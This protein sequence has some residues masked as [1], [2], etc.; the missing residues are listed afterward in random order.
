MYRSGISLVI[1]RVCIGA[2]V[3]SHSVRTDTGGR[4]RGCYNAA[5]IVWCLKEGDGERGMGRLHTRFISMQVFRLGL[6][7]AWIALLY[8]WATVPA[9]AMHTASRLIPLTLLV[10][11]HT[12]L[13]G[14]FMTRIPP[15]R[16]CIVYFA[17]QV[18]IVFAIGIVVSVSEVINI[19][20]GLYIIL[21]AEAARC[22]THLRTL[23]LAVTSLYLLQLSMIVMVWGWDWLIVGIVGSGP[24]MLSAAVIVALF[25]QQATTKAQ[26][27]VLVH[28]LRADQQQL[29]T[30]AA[31]VEDLTLL[32]ERQRLARELHDTLA[33][34]VAG[35]ILQLEA[36]QA[37]LVEGRQLRAQEIVQQA[38][39]RARSTLADSRRAIDDLRRDEHTVDWAAEIQAEL[40]HFSTLGGIRCT[41]DLSFLPSLGTAHGEHIRRMIGEGLSNVVHHAEASE[42][43]VQAHVVD[44][45]VQ[46]S[47]RDNGVGFDPHTIAGQVGH[48]GLLGLRE[49]TQLLG[50]SLLIQSAP[51]A[52]TTLELRLPVDNQGV[53]HDHADSNPDRG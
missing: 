48:Y 3:R 33:Q 6:I 28:Q 21:A 50:G 45:T 38:M 13:H 52:G 2:S 17:V 31:Q 36:A 12:W 44:H 51:G 10:L 16:W 41:V 15:P 23:A 43:W 20:L 35:L 22:F 14:W 37:H 47:I 4:H 30:Y 18:I 19:P 5:I 24:M 11:L 46:I 8:A 39:A 34:G 32:T 27:T 49:R 25:V 40:Q 7:V 42:V 29:A 53:A 9:P 1:V 26:T